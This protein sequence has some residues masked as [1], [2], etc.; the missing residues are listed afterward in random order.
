M[1]AIAAY[2]DAHFVVTKRNGASSRSGAA[3]SAIAR[4]TGEARVAEIG[5]MLTGNKVTA[6]SRKAAEDLL[7]SA[8]DLDHAA[9]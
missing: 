9:E 2:G 8:A 1:A 6:S 3:A 4:V 7:R 5:R